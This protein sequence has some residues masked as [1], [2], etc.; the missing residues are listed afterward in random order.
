[1]PMNFTDKGC[2][3]KGVV[4]S[5]S[6]GM[7]VLAMDE[8]STQEIPHSFFLMRDSKHL[9]PLCSRPYY[10]RYL[11]YLRENEVFVAIS[12]DGQCSIF[13]KSGVEQDEYIKIDG[14]NPSN[15]GP[16]RNGVTIGNEII[17]VGMDR[18]VYRR[19]AHGEWILMEHG[20]VRPSQNEITGFEAI[21]GLDLSKL[22]A[23]GWDGQIW[24]YQS[25][26][27]RQINS[28]TNQILTSVCIDEAGVAYACGRNG[29]LLVGS[30]DTWEV[31]EDTNCPDDL[32]SVACFKGQIYVASLWRL[33]KLVD[34]SLELISDEETGAS[35][36]S[37]ISVNNS[38]LWSIGAK[39]VVAYDGINWVRI[40]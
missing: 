32:W 2:Y 10:T 9:R 34:R 17:V 6:E 14:S 24:L 28:P 12:E 40:G 26:S 7:L 5:S 13:S 3:V 21:A 22:Y 39:D 23:V 38:L 4:A 19:T 25:D 30:E 15:R 35:S 33:Y 36:Y 31:L 1:M 29:L 20:L 8:L 37:I 16:L 11:T 27:W 18:Q